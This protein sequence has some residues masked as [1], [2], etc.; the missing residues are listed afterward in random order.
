MKRI[1]MDVGDHEAEVQKG[2]S[3]VRKVEKRSDPKVA[4]DIAIA[5]A[6]VVIGKAKGEREVVTGTAGGLMVRVLQ[7]FDNKLKN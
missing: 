7:R 2:R 3:I 5:A 1:V 4:N 6:E